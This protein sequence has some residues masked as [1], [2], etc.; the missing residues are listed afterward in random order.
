M[1]GRYFCRSILSVENK[2]LPLPPLKPAKA[3][4]RQS[5]VELLPAFKD[6]KAGFIMPF[7][8]FF[9]THILVIAINLQFPK[10][11]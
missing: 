7:C 8:Y 11:D 5:V 10:F 1:V 2:L 3:N 9:S 4:T 6:K